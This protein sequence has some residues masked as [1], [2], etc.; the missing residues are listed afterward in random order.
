[1]QP[2]SYSLDTPHADGVLT[3]HRMT[4]LLSILRPTP[5]FNIISYPERVLFCFLKIIP[6]NIDLFTGFWAGG[7]SQEN[8]RLST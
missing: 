2:L 4:Y 1:M 8:T 3:E 7:I 6:R 5:F